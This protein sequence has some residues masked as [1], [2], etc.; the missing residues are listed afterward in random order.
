MRDLK[1]KDLNQVLNVGYKVN[2]CRDHVELRNEAL[3]MVQQVL[4]ANSSVYLR[5]NKNHQGPRFS[6]GIAHGHPESE[7]LKWCHRYQPQDPF[8]GCYLRQYKDQNRQVIVSDRVVN[9][10]EYLASRFYQ[11]FLEPMSIYHVLVIGLTS[12]TGP[13]GILGFHRPRNAPAFSDREVDMARMIAPY[14]SAASART[15]ALEK[16]DERDWIINCLAENNLNQNLLVLDQN[17]DPIFVSQS[18]YELLGEANSQLATMD[19]TK[20]PLPRE[21]RQHCLQ[22]KRKYTSDNPELNTIKFRM[23]TGP[24]GQPVNVSA[25]AMT[26]NENNLRIM[27]CF[28]KENAQKLSAEQLEKHGLTPRQIDIVQLVGVGLTNSS[29]AEKLCIS[30]RTVENHLRS[31]FEKAGVNNR[32]SLVYRLALDVH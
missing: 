21:L 22:L 27:V 32:T 1:S 28:E 9:E 3:C 2:E 11:E 16:V 29:I 17:L 18:S 31:I 30:T 23:H 19:K 12:R 14:F 15:G 8:A 20:L 26:W 10:R 24:E 6:G 7:M 13:L 4:S 5:V 25:R